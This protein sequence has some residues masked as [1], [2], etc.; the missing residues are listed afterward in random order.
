M[1]TT[2]DIS[3]GFY[4]NLQTKLDLGDDK[5]HELISVAVYKIK[6]NKM[7]MG[8][9]RRIEMISVKWEANQQQM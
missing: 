7:N 5:S 9:R 8:W 2:L 4:W 3:S 1:D 6:W